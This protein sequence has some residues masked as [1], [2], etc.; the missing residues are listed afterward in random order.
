[1]KEQQIPSLFADTIRM[2]TGRTDLAEKFLQISM[3][4]DFGLFFPAQY[5]QYLPKLT[6][7]ECVELARTTPF[8]YPIIRVVFPRLVEQQTLLPKTMP[9]QKRIKMGWRKWWEQRKRK[10]AIT[11]IRAELSFWGVDVSN[12][13]DE[14]LERRVIEFGHTIAS[15]GVTT[16]EAVAG[17]VK[18]GCIANKTLPTRMKGR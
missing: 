7:A 8:A 17:L 13:S 6:D 18:M 9:K 11:R 4:F 14:E 16:D 10:M 1:M 12:M 5:R 15:L 2:A 3:M